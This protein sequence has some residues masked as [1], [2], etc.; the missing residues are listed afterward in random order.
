[1]ASVLDIVYKD[2]AYKDNLLIVFRNYPLDKSCNPSMQ[3][4]LHKNACRVAILARCA[5]QY[6]K[7]WQ[8]HDMALGR[9]SSISEKTAKDWALFVGLTEEQI[10]SCMNSKA[11]VDKIRADVDLGNKVGVNSTPTVFINGRRLE[12]GANVMKVRAAI[13]GILAGLPEDRL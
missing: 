2:P 3:Q 10:S 8:Y 5:G 13:D 4:E 9:Q 12:G 7:F 6:G 11:I 1:M